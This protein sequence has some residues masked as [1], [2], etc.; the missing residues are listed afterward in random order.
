[1]HFHGPEHFRLDS[2]RRT[3]SNAIAVCT[4]YAM[5]KTIFYVTRYCMQES[6]QSQPFFDSALVLATI[7]TVVMI[8]M[9]IACGLWTS[10]EI[11]R[12]DLRG[13]TTSFFRL[14]SVP[15]AFHSV[16]SFVEAVVRQ[17]YSMVFRTEARNSPL[18]TTLWVGGVGFPF[19]LLFCW[20]LKLRFDRL[21]KIE[22]PALTMTLHGDGEDSPL[23]FHGSMCYVSKKP[24]T[25]EDHQRKGE[26][27]L[28]EQ[29]EEE[30]NHSKTIASNFFVTRIL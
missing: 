5:A 6:H 28:S 10:I 15:L 30:S 13:A 2:W 25:A 7:R 12:R 1:M 18:L 17:L 27:Q 21:R 29:E 26:S 9:H 23:I 16:F 11:V 3:C 4:G 8:P 14:I 22:I 19:V 24:E 20:R